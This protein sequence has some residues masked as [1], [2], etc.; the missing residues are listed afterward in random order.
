MT[1]HAVHV[2]LYN[3]QAT[4]SVTQH[5]RDL[6]AQAGIPV[7]GVSETL[8]SNEQTYQSWQLDQAKTLLKAL[9]N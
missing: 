8:P 3:T 7:V 5:V 9:G 2:L 1:T 6:A 4:S